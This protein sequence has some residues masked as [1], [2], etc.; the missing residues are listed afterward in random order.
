MKIVH[1]MNKRLLENVKYQ[2]ISISKIFFG[3]RRFVWMVKRTSASHIM[4]LQRH[5][6]S[7]TYMYHASKSWCRSRNWNRIAAYPRFLWLLPPLLLFDGGGGWRVR[8]HII[9]KTWNSLVPAA[10]VTARFLTFYVINNSVHLS[11]HFQ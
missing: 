2:R 1:C 5:K 9:L 8:E 11:R 4:W 10:A 7:I 3:K 6:S